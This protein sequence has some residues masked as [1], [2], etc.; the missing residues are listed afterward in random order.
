MKE[1]NG[2]FVIC[3]EDH[4]LFECTIFLNENVLYIIVATPFSH[5]NCWNSLPSSYMSS[6]MEIWYLI[7]CVHDMGLKMVF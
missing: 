4:A 6:I 3:W 1:E 2:C 7:S 5:L